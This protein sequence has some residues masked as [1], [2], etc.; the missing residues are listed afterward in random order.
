MRV[1]THPKYSY[2]RV[3]EIPKNE[4][5]KLDFAL[6]KQPTETL[7]AYYKRQTKKP[8]ILVNGGF[9]SMTDGVTCFNFRD[10]NNTIMYNDS[11]QWGMG[12]VGDN[13]IGFGHMNERPWR[14]FISGY[15]NLI[16]HGKKLSI[17]FAKELNYKARRSMLG[18]NDTTVFIVCVENPGLAYPAMQDLMFELGCT[19]A[20]NLDGGG[21]TKMLHD[22]KSVTTNLTNRA[23]DN[24]VAVYLKEGVATKNIDV[25]YQSYS[26]SMWLGKITNYNEFNGNGYS[27]VEGRPIQALKIKL[28]EGSVQYRAHTTD[29]KWWGWITD[30]VG[31]GPNSYS[32]V[33]GRNIDAIQIRLIGDIAE[34]YDIKYRVSILNDSNY[35]PWVNDTE[36]YAG[37]FGHPIDKIQMY[38]TNK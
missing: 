30:S 17:T 33:F 10:E 4:I 21:S 2:V 36:G 18:Y 3:A 27:G 12:I 14:D 15:P 13:E 23:I 22:G 34:K 19:Y 26:K 9:F 32:G 29:G 28:S 6:C 35:L 5:E 8:N 16:E 25:I 38:I 1:Y 20:I 7:G 24:V 37:M 31:N 11:Y